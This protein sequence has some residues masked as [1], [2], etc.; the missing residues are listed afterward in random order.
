MGIKIIAIQLDKSYK[1]K[2]HV[3]KL[4]NDQRNDELQSFSRIMAFTLWLI[5]SQKFV[6]KTQLLKTAKISK[7]LSE[8]RLL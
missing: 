3:S 2:L 7:C 5:L 8:L 1:R 4:G 6:D